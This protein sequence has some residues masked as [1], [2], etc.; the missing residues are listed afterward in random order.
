MP[1]ST[2]KVAAA[3]PL[4]VTAVAPLK[5]VPVKVTDVP[6]SPVAG[7]KLVTVGMIARNP[8]LVVARME[9]SLPAAQPWVTSLKATAL[10]SAVIPEICA[11]QVAPPFVVARMVPPVPTAQA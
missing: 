4:K 5:P 11:L 3:A 8:P 2:L 9:P 10:R 7:R 6:A 1:E